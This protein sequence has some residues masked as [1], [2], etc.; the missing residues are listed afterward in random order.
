LFLFPN[1]DIAAEAQICYVQKTIRNL[2][3]EEEIADLRMKWKWVKERERL[4]EKHRGGNCACGVCRA[5]LGIDLNEV[6]Q[7]EVDEYLLE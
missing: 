3:K 6:E 4:F 5:E 7:R 1:K 2:K